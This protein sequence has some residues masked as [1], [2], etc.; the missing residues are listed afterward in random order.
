[1]DELKADKLADELGGQ[2]YRIDEDIWVVVIDR[3]DGRLVVL[4]D[5]SVDEYAD[6]QAFKSGRCF[7]T[8]RLG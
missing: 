1:M 3:R 6:W 2:A 8:I 4:T 7:A 5:C